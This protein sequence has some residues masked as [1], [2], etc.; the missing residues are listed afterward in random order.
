MSD[1]AVIATSSSGAKKIDYTLTK[2]LEYA[3]E[4]KKIK[5]KLNKKC[6]GKG[7]N[8]AKP[9]TAVDIERA[10]WSWSILDGDV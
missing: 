9:F 3:N 7:E 1:E 4:I 6:G 2:Y 8:G 5:T 10:L